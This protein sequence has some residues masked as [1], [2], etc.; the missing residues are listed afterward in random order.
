MSHAQLVKEALNR[1]TPEQLAVV[2][3]DSSLALEDQLPDTLE[4]L[5]IVDSENWEFRTYSMSSDIR[6][7]N[8]TQDLLDYIDTNLEKV[9]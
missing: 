4:N 9:I 5:L 8:C 1:F 6:P 3:V 2:Y 7:A